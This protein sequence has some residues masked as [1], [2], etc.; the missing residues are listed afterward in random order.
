MNVYRIAREK[1]IRDLSGEGA[2]LFGGRWNRRGTPM[3]YASE[4]RSLAA[5]EVL[6]H[7]SAHQLPEDLMILTLSLPDEPSPRIVASDD[8]PD[9][10]RKYPA[11]QHLAEL[12]S[13]WAESKKSVLLKVP[14]AVMPQEWNLLL[15]PQHEGMSRVEIADI[16]PFSFDGR[17]MG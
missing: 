10:W 15:N 17:L 1:F 13:I 16:T 8:L 9:Q 2:R 7:T 11:P 12:G 14:S 5:L 3:I 4:Y 6:V